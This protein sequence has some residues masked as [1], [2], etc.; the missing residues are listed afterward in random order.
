[1]RRAATRDEQ[2]QLPAVAAAAVVAAARAAR[3]GRGGGVGRDEARSAQHDAEAHHHPLLARR[4]DRARLAAPRARYDSECG[5]VTTGD[6]WRSI[7]TRARSDS[8][9]G[10]V[11]KT[12]GRAL[13]E[14][15]PTVFYV[16]WLRPNVEPFIT[17]ERAARVA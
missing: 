10:L 5:L 16:G 14:R 1:M 3:V 9:C 17:R 12:D 11:R 8:E 15:V 6:D 4:H 7:L 13:R 2:Q